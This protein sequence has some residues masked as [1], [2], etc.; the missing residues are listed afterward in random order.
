MMQIV[1]R[2]SFEVQ[3]GDRNYQF[4]INPAAPIDE[5][6]SVLAA[7][8]HHYTQVK[9]AQDKAKQDLPK[10]DHVEAISL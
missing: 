1:A 4:I 7:V 9:E 8:H 5:F 10:D 2:T 3:T 6:L